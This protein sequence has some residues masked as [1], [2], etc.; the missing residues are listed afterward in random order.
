MSLA[1]ERERVEIEPDFAADL[2]GFADEFNF[3][4]FAKNEPDAEGSPIGVVDGPDAAGRAGDAEASAAGFG[5]AEGAGAAFK[6]IDPF[7]E[8]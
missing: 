5:G 7:I 8:E 3:S 2:A 6:D 1:G 4:G